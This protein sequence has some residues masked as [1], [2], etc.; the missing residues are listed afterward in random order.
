MTD[1]EIL[2][3]GYTERKENFKHSPYIETSFQKNYV[4]EIGKKY[5]ILIYKWNS[6]KYK[7]L[8]D[9]STYDFDVKLY[10]K[11]KHSPV[12]LN[13]FNGWELEEVEKYLEEMFN[14]GLFDYYE[15]R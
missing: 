4:D 1:K 12:N 10:S 5:S 14:T 11:D 9:T 3:A 2:D 13:F 7:F 15:R 8:V 6:K